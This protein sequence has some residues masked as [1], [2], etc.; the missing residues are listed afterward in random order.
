MLTVV[1][2]QSRDFGAAVV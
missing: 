2:I 1:Q